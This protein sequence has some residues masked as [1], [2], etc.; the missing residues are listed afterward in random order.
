MLAQ[1]DPLEYGGNGYYCKILLADVEGQQ[2]ATVFLDFYT[3]PGKCLRSQ[4]LESS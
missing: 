1:V 3:L 4:S 2:A